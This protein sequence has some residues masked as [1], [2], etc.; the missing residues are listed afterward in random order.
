VVG[1]LP[2]FLEVGS[3]GIGIVSQRADF[4]SGRTDK[5]L[6]LLGLGIVKLGYVDMSD[7]G[8]PPLRLADGPAHHFNTIEAGFGREGQDL[9]Q[10]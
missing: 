2:S 10:R 4:D 7:P 9:L 6:D 1:I 8:I 3:Q 5:L